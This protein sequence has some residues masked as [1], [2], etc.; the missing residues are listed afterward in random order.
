M[1]SIVRAV[2]DIDPTFRG[3]MAALVYVL[4]V[5]A[6][7]QGLLRLKKHSDDPHR[8]PSGMG[9]AMTFVLAAALLALPAFMAAATGTLLN[10]E[11][12]SGATLAYNTGSG[13]ADTG[14]FNALIGALFTIISLV[15]LIAFIRG[16]F[17]LRG[18]ADG[19]TQQT[20]ASGIWHL[21]GGV[22]AWHILTVID[23]F[24]QTL[25]VSVLT[26]N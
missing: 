23:V 11:T 15:G 7:A 8:A 9:T 18:A 6:L 2:S 5:I 25:G 10:G 21:V 26:I 13:S 16:W 19:N 4:G 12:R 17:V 1:D 20:I 14:A 3:F 24:Q 22:M